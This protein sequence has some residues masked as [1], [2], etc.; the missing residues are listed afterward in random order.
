MVLLVW[1]VGGGEWELIKF[2]V[3]WGDGFGW[4]WGGLKLI[5]GVEFGLKKLGILCLFYGY[6]FW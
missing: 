1:D 6:E 4:S 2:I 5:F 3:G